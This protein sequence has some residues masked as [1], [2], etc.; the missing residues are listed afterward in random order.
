MAWV[1]VH[2]LLN[3]LMPFGDFKQS[4]IG[5]EIDHAAIK[6]YTED[7]SACTVY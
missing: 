5:R 1:N 6:T 4:D 3:P 7:K 2:D